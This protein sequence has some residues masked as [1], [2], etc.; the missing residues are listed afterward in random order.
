VRAIFSTSVWLQAGQYLALA[1]QIPAK[2]KSGCR[3]LRRPCE[4]RAARTTG[5]GHR[6]PPLQLAACSYYELRA[7]SY[8]GE[9]LC[10]LFLVFVSCFLFLVPEIISCP[11]HHT[12]HHALRLCTCLFPVPMHM[13]CARSPSP[14][15][16]P[17]MR[18]APGS[19]HLASGIFF[20]CKMRDAWAMGYMC[21]S[22]CCW[23]RQR[24]VAR[25]QR[26]I[27]GL[28]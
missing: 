28:C 12:T 23:A 21:L 22:R 16:N 7:T 19:W 9:V 3:P 5:T 17:G 8:E 15:P 20:S 10:A 13:P 18:C 2:Q 6:A 27:R 26:P 11:T 25:L 4:L 1:A 24:R 14:S